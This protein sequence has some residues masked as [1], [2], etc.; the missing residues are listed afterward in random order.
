VSPAQ[1]LQPALVRVGAPRRGV[2]GGR[3]RH[4]DEDFE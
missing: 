3:S 2:P 1:G 4:H